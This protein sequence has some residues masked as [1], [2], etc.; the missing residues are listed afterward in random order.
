M[1][2]EITKSILNRLRHKNKYLKWPSRENFLVYKKAINLC[3]SLNK[4]A[5]K[6]YFEKTTENRIMGSKKIWSTVKPLFSS[7][8]FIHNDN[9]PIEIDNNIIEDEPELA[10]QFNLHYINAVKVTTSE[11]P[12]K[13]GTLACKVSQKCFCNYH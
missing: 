8:G 13:L 3:S 5:K 4:K 7:K 1:T 2:K 6:I 12:T 11:H 10:K 9:I